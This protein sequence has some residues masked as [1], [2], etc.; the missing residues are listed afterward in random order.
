M[1]DCEATGDPTAREDCRFTLAQGLLDQ[2]EALQAALAQVSE[3]DSRDLLLLRLA[4]A[5]PA[6]SGPLCAQ[7]QSAPARDKCRQVLGRPHLSTQPP[8]GPSGGTPPGS[9][10]AGPPPG[11]PGGEAP[12]VPAP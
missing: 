5:A 9:P 1:A 7:V 4:V 12:P 8:P 11:S 2:P 6:R 3:P 10:A